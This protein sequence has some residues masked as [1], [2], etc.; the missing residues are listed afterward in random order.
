MLLWSGEAGE[1]GVPI[2]FDLPKEGEPVSPVASLLRSG[3]VGDCVAG[4]KLCSQVVIFE[5]TS[6]GSG[7]ILKLFGICSW[8]KERNRLSNCVSDK[9]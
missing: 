6:G 5:A 8:I 9:W 3:S 7:Q 4:G 1:E 2:E